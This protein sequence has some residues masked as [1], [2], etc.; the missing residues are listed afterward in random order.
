MKNATAIKQSNISSEVDI[1]NYNT[2]NISSSKQQTTKITK[3]VISLREEINVF[4]HI[5]D[6]NTSQSNYNQ[7]K[8]RISLQSTGP[9]IFIDRR[10]N[11]TNRRSSTSSNITEL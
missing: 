5:S 11:R 8:R 3:E 2:V 7:S 9:K 1:K 4:E 10:H 6:D